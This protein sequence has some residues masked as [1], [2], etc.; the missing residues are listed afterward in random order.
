MTSGTVTITALSSVQIKITKR[1]NQ[2]LDTLPY[3]NVSTALDWQVNGHF[4]CC[5]IWRSVIFQLKDGQ[6]VVSGSFLFLKAPNAKRPRTN[7]SVLQA[8]QHVVFSESRGGQ[9]LRG[10]SARFSCNL[11]FDR[12]PPPPGS[13][14]LRSLCSRSN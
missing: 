5:V 8:T 14:L 11:P 1:R 9:R 3:R 7:F 13:S 2:H 12:S 6:Q 10:S 4:C